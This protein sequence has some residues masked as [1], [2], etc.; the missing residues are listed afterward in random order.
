ML[1]WIWKWLLFWTFSKKMK[2]FQV[3]YL[4]IREQL[5]YSVWRHQ[6]VCGFHLPVC[7]VYDHSNHSI[8]LRANSLYQHTYHPVTKPPHTHTH[9]QM[10]NFK[11]RKLN[12][13]I[14]NRT[15]S[16][17]FVMLYRIVP[18]IKP[19]IS[20]QTHVLRIQCLQEQRNVK[21]RN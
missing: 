21:L 12:T 20:D 17:G 10:K 18:S 4:V 8:V 19:C 11:E 13:I 15:T 2:S 16:W 14:S 5:Q 1:C 3:F 9:T 6:S 7:Y